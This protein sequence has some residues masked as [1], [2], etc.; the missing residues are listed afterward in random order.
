[1]D[2]DERN[3]RGEPAHLLHGVAAGIRGPH[4]REPLALEEPH[5]GR[6]E[7][8]AVVDQEHS[9]RHGSSIRSVRV[10]GITA[11]RKI[12]NSPVPGCPQSESR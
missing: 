3:L 7:R 12:A 5:G 8:I 11:S 4:D 2:V 9:D 10:G 1:V 6:D